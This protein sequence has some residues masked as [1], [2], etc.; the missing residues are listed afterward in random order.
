MNCQDPCGTT[1]RLNQ[2]S[3]MNLLRDNSDGR[4]YSDGPRELVHVLVTHDAS[5][6]MQA[7][8]CTATRLAGVPTDALN[9]K[10]SARATRMTTLM[11]DLL[12]LPPP[13]HWGINE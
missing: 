13:P 11:E 2:F 5:A 4:A 3:F 10:L 6:A 1:I 12:K 8:Q 7:T 9:W